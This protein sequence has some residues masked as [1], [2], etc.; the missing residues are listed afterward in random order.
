VRVI[1]ERERV[2]KKGRNISINAEK[3]RNLSERDSSMSL[4]TQKIPLKDF[5]RGSFSEENLRRGE[6]RELSSQ[7]LPSES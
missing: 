1:G 7:Y 6:R 4:K 2:V 5:S 3:E